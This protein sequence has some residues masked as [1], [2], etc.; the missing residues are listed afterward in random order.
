MV[1]TRPPAMFIADALA[2]DFLNSVATPV[3]LPIDW[4]GDG[5]GFLA[6]LEQAGLVPP[7][8]LGRLQGAG[9]AGG[10]RQRRRSGPIVA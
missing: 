1:H 9:N 8:V 7:S 2:L 4:I 6:W 10:I 3:D 5:E